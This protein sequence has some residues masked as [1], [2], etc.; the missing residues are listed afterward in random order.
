MGKKIQDENGNVY[1]QK[2]PFYKRVWFWILALIVLFVIIGSL[3]G[4]NDTKKVAED[5]KS[6]K[7]E[8]T[9]EKEYNIGDTVSYKGYEIKVNNVKYIESEEFSTPKAGNHYVLVNITIKNNTTE[10]QTYNP[11]DYKLNADGNAINLS[12][13]LSS[14]NDQLNS[15]D[16]DKGASVTGTMVGQAKI[17]AKSLK[18]QYHSSF[19]ND[20]TVDIKLK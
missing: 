16:L 19:W 2:K 7:Q 5:K 3:G 1:V 11:F 18:L 10:K 12:E 8:S 6:S 9:L 13:Y 17:D 20:K 14:V 15:G 4:N